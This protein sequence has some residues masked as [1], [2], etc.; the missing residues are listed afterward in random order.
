M[1]IRNIIIFF[2]INVFNIFI[3]KYN[4]QFIIYLKFNSFNEVTLYTR[5]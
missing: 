5:Y 2:S 3:K 1:K 4:I